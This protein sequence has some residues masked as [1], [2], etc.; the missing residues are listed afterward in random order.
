M[1]TRSASH[2]GHSRSTARLRREGAEEAAL[3]VAS[4]PGTAWRRTRQR[5]RAPRTNLAPAIARPSGPRGTGSTQRHQPT[6][7]TRSSTRQSLRNRKACPSRS[8]PASRRARSAKQTADTKPRPN[9]AGQETA[10]KL[11]RA[12]RPRSPSRAN[13][14]HVPARP[15]RCVTQTAIRVTMRYGHYSHLYFSSTNRHAPFCLAT[16]RFQ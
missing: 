16:S 8:H 12:S 3:R 4:P 9:V 13:M 10:G 15:F 7:R 11:R 5:R 6:S 1:I 14:K 2:L